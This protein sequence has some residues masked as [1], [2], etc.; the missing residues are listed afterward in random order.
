MTVHNSGSAVAASLINGTVAGQIKKF[1][2]I[3]AGAVTLTPATYAQGTTIVLAQHD[4]AE[5]LWT[6][7]TWYDLGQQTLRDGAT[8]KIGAQ[9]S[10]LATTIGHATS[11]VTV[12][13]NLTVTGNLTV[14]GTTTT[15]N[16][17]TVAIADPIFEI[18]ADGSDDNLD[19]GI[20]M[21][22]NAG[23]AAKNAFM[24]FDESDNKFAFIPDATD[25]NN[26]FSG[27]IVW[28]GKYS[29]EIYL[30]HFVVIYVL[31]MKKR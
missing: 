10:G 15:V 1:V 5:L 4:N 16:S 28:L 22:Y 27:S 30:F 20:K 18:G 19:R 24:G 25:T 11:E 12:G 6:G 9:T 21:K 8:L 14:S 29:L 26:V 23:G 2:N 31:Q 17:S 13:D 7:S 3:G